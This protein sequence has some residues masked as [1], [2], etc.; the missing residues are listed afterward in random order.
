ML[1]SSFTAFKFPNPSDW[2]IYWKFKII[3]EVQESCMF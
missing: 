2:I 1:Q 3:D